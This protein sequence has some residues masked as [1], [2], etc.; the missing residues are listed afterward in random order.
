[1]TALRF[2]QDRPERIRP[3]GALR[4]FRVYNRR[5]VRVMYRLRDNSRSPRY[6]LL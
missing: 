2:T 1:M 3:A 5:I 6:G 4:V